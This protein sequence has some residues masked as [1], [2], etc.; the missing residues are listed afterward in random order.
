M[1]QNILITIIAVLLAGWFLYA[2]L[3]PLF[4]KPLKAVSKISGH[5][6]DYYDVFGRVQAA[7]QK[8]DF[9]RVISLTDS[10]L[11]DRPFE[12]SALRYQAFA[13][14]HLQRHAEAKT[15]FERLDTLPGEDAAKMLQKIEDLTA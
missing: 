8:G 4:H 5:A 14:F 7:F 15:A 3:A 13:L 10:I 12:S 9:E 2:V 1:Y 11:T 6:P